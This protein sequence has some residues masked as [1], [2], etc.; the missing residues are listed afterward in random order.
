MQPAKSSAD[1]K[2]NLFDDIS[3]V[4]IITCL[5]CCTEVLNDGYGRYMVGW[6]I[7]IITLQ[8][9]IV[10][11]AISL[12]GPITKIRL[13]IK[14]CYV[15]RKKKGRRSIKYAKKVLK[16]KFKKKISSTFEI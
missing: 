10:N 5:V 4:L 9:V 2:L 6:L 16:Q 8:N 15:V 12:I 1:N 11:I 14:W 3:L 13:F 7:L